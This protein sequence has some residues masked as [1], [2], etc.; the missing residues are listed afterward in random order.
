[1]YVLLSFVIVIYKPVCVCV[2][3]IIYCNIYIYVCL[4]AI[5]NYNCYIYVCVC[6]CVCLQKHDSLSI[7]KL[8][9]TFGTLR[10]A[11]YL[12]IVITLR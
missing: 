5:I 10:N 9:A 7:Y 1:M 8:N 4:C 12:F 3:S 11:E 2:L 6:V